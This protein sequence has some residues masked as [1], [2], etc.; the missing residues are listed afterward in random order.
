M[1]Y[2]GFLCAFLIE[3]PTQYSSV[4]ENMRGC[5]QSY[6]DEFHLIKRK[7]IFI[8]ICVLKSL[9]ELHD[10]LTSEQKYAWLRYPP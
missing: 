1:Y 7:Y 4:T 8:L 2:T 9:I 10:A 3:Y 5:Y 6:N